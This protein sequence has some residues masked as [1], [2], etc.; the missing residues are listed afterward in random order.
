MRFG[1]I[2]FK[3]KANSRLRVGLTCG[4]SSSRLEVRLVTDSPKRYATAAAGLGWWSGF[5]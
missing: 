4:G 5:P 1:K 2:T 3:S